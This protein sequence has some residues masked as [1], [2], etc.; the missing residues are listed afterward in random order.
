MLLHKVAAGK[1]PLIVTSCQT[2]CMAFLYNFLCETTLLPFRVPAFT[3]APH[4]NLQFDGYRLVVLQVAT[5]LVMYHMTEKWPFTTILYMH[6]S[7]MY[8]VGS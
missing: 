1:L 6:I 3:V 5:S 2:S 7:L 4:L 8:S